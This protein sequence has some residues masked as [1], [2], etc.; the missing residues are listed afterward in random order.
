MFEG[1]VRAMMSLKKK[2]KKKEE[3]KVEAA[4]GKKKK[5]GD[6]LKDDDLVKMGNI[7]SGGAFGSIRLST[8]TPSKKKRGCCG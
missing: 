6:K 7:A 8:V 5:G 3:E 2:K 4:G 1:L